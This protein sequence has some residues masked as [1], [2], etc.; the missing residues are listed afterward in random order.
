MSAILV[1]PRGHKWALPLERSLPRPE[2]PSEL[3]ACRWWT[4]LLPRRSGEDSLR[5]GTPESSPGKS[6]MARGKRPVRTQMTGKLQLLAAT[7]TWR[8]AAAWRS[9]L[10][11]GPREGLPTNEGSA[12][13]PSEAAYL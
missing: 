11:G 6:W 12:G 7:P 13:A 10:R 3:V 9:A 1:V 8:Q 2:R 5:L 4:L